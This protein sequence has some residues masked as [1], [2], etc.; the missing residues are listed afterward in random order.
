MKYLY[1]RAKLGNGGDVMPYHELFLQ[2][3][4]RNKNQAARY[5]E[6]TLSS[7]ALG[8]NMLKMITIEGVVEIDMLK[9][10][11]R[12]Y[13]LAS[14]KLDD[15]A[16]EFLKENK[17]DLLPSKIFANFLQGTPDK[18]KEIAVYCL[19]DCE[20]VNRLLMKLETLANNIG[21]ANVCIVPLSFLF[22]RGQGVK[23]FS[24]VSK[25]CREDGFLIKVVT[26]KEKDDS[27]YEGAIVFPPKPDIY[28]EPVGVDDFGSLYPSSMISE[29]ISHDSIVWIREY[30]NDKKMIAESGNFEYDGLSGFNYNDIMYDTFQEI[31]EL[32]KKG[33]KKK[34]GKKVKIGYKICRYAEAKTGEK[35]V[36]PRILQK[37]LTARKDTRKKIEMRKITYRRGSET[38]E[39]YGSVEK[40]DEGYPISKTDI[41]RIDEVVKV[42][43]DFNDF[44]KKVLDGLQIAFKLTANSLYGQVGA[45]T[46]P[47]CYKELAAS[48]TAVG[49]KMVC[50]ARDTV[51]EKFPGSVL[52]YGDTDSVF[53]NYMGY[54]ETRHGKNLTDYEKLKYTAEYCAEGAALVTSKLKRPQTLNFEKIL[55]PF[56]IFAKKRYVGNKYENSITKFKQINMGVVL[57]R[58]DNAKIVKEI[59]GGI[60]NTILNER[61]IQ[62]S[63][64]FFRSSVVNL[65]EGKVDMSKLMISKSL[66]GDYVNPT[67]IAHKVLAERMGER[68]PGNKPAPSDR[69]P[70]C[71]IDI[72]NLRCLKC[73]DKINA[74][75]CKCLRCMKL[76]C[77]KHLGNHRNL[78]NVVCRFCHCPTALECQTCRGWF[79][80]EDMKKHYGRCTDKC[81]P[82]KGKCVK[83]NAANCKEKCGTCGCYVCQ[84]DAKE[85]GESHKKCRDCSKTGAESL[86]MC[87]TCLVMFCE[88][89]L[90]KHPNKCKKPIVPK[91]LQGDLIE[92]PQ[93]IKDNDLKID[94]RYYLDHQI[95]VP[96]LQ[97]FSLIMRDPESLIEAAIRRDNNKKSGNTELT[98][99]FKIIKVETDVSVNTTTTTRN[100]LDD[101]EVEEH[102]IDVDDEEPDIVEID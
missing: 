86:K 17:V 99:W 85:H 12:D 69:L 41:I 76:F 7:S 49:R 52:V 23:I 1:I 25:Q 96:C 66:K 97:I 30:D 14:Y 42:V 44:Q 18:I 75:N 50:I 51:L 24:L 20:L 88:N 102:F 34:K 55:F 64:E 56:I 83:C 3:L 98:E 39:F 2:L 94:Y 16:A 46:S 81:E 63:K 78:C 89:H 40:T 45:S 26:K 29:N 73:A 47:I 48:T 53:I 87:E 92:H 33:R 27:S 28:M 22:V 54:I 57:K 90:I 8:D 91:L 31:K 36:L 9:V 43:D 100:W 93:Y 59:F 79:C 68:D 15:V 84:K 95:Q 32:D 80:E 21:M 35:N 13:K 61:D 74:D 67:Q 5:E 60:I 82:I 11:Q 71:Y 10:V 77:G 37:L 101:D 62:K 58:R 70:Y 72:K 19:K 65:L 4:N 6:K 38:R